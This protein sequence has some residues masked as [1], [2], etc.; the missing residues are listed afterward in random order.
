VAVFSHSASLVA[1]LVALKELGRKVVEEIGNLFLL[2]LI[3]ALVV[4][5]RV[6]SAGQ[7]FANGEE[8]CS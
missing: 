5:D 4:V 6:F 1:F 7:Q 2:P 3:L 8:W